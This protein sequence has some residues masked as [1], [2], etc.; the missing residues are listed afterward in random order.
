MSGSGLFEGSRSEPQPEFYNLGTAKWQRMLKDQDEAAFEQIGAGIGHVEGV[1]GREG[2]EIG[3]HQQA[4]T[5]LQLQLSR[6]AE[7]LRIYFKG[8]LGALFQDP[9]KP[10]LGP[11]FSGEFIVPAVFLFARGIATS[12]QWQERKQQLGQT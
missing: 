5:A 8:T 2:G 6:S 7:A 10:P 9:V 4:I 11:E 12:A 1:T 3:P